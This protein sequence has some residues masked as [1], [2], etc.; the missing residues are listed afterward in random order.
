MGQRSQIYIHFNVSGNEGMIARYF[1]WNYGKHM[2]SRAR[3][4][5]E[6]L[7]NQYKGNPFMFQGT[8]NITR[9]NRF[10]DIDFD[11]RNM[12]ISV[13][14][15]EYCKS[16]GIF[17]TESIFGQPNNDGQLLIDVTDNG[18]R[19]CFIEYYTDPNP[20]NAEQYMKWN[21]ECETYPDRHEP[22]DY[23]ERNIAF[24]DAVA[25]LMTEQEVREFLDRDYSLLL[26]EAPK[27]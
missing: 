16:N 25:E 6:F 18:I 2:V 12:D 8:E 11:M 7:E 4:I 20:M 24:I 10:C 14:I 17:D 5:M 19:Y 22:D 23:K 13:D 27:F 26:G 3:S 15:L 1:Q 21:T 9:L